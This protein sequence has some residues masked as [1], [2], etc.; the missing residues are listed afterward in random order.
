MLSFDDLFRFH[1]LLNPLVSSLTP[2]PKGGK[3][4][5]HIEHSLG[6]GISEFCHTNQI[7]AMWLTRDYHV[8]PC[9]SQL[10]LYM[11]AVDVLPCQNSALS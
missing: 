8:T 2:P 9:Y 4:L 10:M 11:R 6:L 5:V 3:G 1:H 7:H